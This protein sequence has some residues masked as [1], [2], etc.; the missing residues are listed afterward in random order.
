MYSFFILFALS[1]LGTYYAMPH[2][3][4]KLRENG[5]VVK[6][7]YKQDN[8]LIPTN[9]GMILLFTS[10]ISNDIYSKFILS[11]SLNYNISYKIHFN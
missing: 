4:R 5:Y 10:F 2:S 11:F 9:A 6:D 1:F 7:M 8:P 3:I